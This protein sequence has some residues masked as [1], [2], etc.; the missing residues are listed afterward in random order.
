MTQ[1]FFA[2]EMLCDLAS[3]CEPFCKLANWRTDNRNLVPHL[4]ENHLWSSQLSSLKINDV[5]TPSASTLDQIQASRFFLPLLLFSYGWGENDTSL[6]HPSISSPSLTTELGLPDDQVCGM[7][8]GAQRAGIKQRCCSGPQTGQ[9]PCEHQKA[10]GN[11]Q[12][13]HRAGP[14]AAIR[15]WLHSSC[16]VCTGPVSRC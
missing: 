1:V 14:R 16:T 10:A 15:R 6:F 5:E 8:V 2:A 12:Y 9:K 11:L 3:I 13:L 7:C 4:D